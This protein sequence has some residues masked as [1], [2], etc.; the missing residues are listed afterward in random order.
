MRAREVNAGS[1]FDRAIV[2]HR[3]TVDTSAY[4]WQDPALA[5]IGSRRS[6]VK[7]AGHSVQTAATGSPQR[8]IVRFGAYELDSRAGELRK[9]GYRIR[10]QNKPLRILELLLVQ[11][12]EVVTREELRDEL[13][14]QDVHVDFDH[15]L[16]SAVNKLREALR[17]SAAQPRYI[18]TT[19]RGYRFI[20]QIETTVREVAQ[21]LPAPSEFA[22][23]PAA[24]PSWRKRT[25]AAIALGAVLVAIVLG[26]L[27]TL[28]LRARP[29]P[30]QVALA[31]LP[32]QN[33]S[34]DASQEFFSEG[35]TDELIAQVGRIA[36]DELRVIARA[37]SMR[38]RQT[39]KPLDQIG[40]E[41]GVD[42]LL[43]GSV[44]R[45]GSRVRI[46][47]RLVR[48]R[49]QANVW[50][51]SYERDVRDVLAL[52]TD[53]ARAIAEE[54]EVT[55][56]RTGPRAGR[57]RANVEPAVYEAYLKGRYFLDRSTKPQQAVDYFEKAIAEDTSYAPAYAGLADAYGQLGWAM[58]AEV[59][60]SEA[61]ASALRAAQKAL[62][63][64]EDLASAHV[65]L[66]RVRWKYE[67]DWRA[68]E[69]SLRRA[70]ELDPNSAEAHESYFDL[71][72]AMGRHEDAYARLKRAAALDPVSVTITYDFGLHFARTGEYAR[73]IDWLKKAIEL[74]P[75]SGFVHHLLGETYAEQG[76]L[77]ESADELKKAIELSGPSPH[78]TA[79]LAWVQHRAGDRDAPGRVLEELRARANHGYVSPHSLAL[80]HASAGNV[81]EALTY[82]ERAYEQRDPWLSLIHVQPQFSA[83]A[84]QPRFDK[85]MVRMGLSDENTRH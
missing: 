4:C 46:T 23:P 3:L 51:Q 34:A 22:P 76:A 42:Y 74:D 62:S 6:P 70:I 63:L 81:K 12:G 19:L 1:V 41:L 80:L 27:Q 59:S 75:A 85:L 50:S 36:P 54:V 44:L 83:L 61:Y 40:R 47:G 15:G 24:P 11:P 56:M 30:S 68:A 8:S 16:N 48:V 71:L 38:Y 73:A 64:D 69:Q 49:D 33:L 25:P 78:F 77:A 26:G 57:T 14:P 21:D 72:S 52:Q 9:H 79:A 31:V 28:R 65:A 18:E 13:W 67:Y 84:G 17:D 2:P 29:T 5:S 55:F 45:A 7:H 53:V 58:S 43:E 39:D 66:A 82:L 20:A 35:F 10:L 60:P 32:F 37:S